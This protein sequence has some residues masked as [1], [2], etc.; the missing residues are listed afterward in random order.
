MIFGYLDPLG[1]TPGSGKRS[2]EPLGM[3]HR[4]E[5]FEVTEASGR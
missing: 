1:C 4:D 5:T 3:T 2:S